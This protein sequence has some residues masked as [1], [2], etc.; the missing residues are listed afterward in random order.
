MCVCV[1]VQF[2]LFALADDIHHL[3]NYRQHPTICIVQFNPFK[4]GFGIERNETLLQNRLG[5]EPQAGRAFGYGLVGRG[6]PG[7]S[8]DYSCAININIPGEGE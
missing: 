6:L 1:C 8:R 4:N 5:P 2:F 3:L 7:L